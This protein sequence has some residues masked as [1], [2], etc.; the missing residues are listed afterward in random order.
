[1]SW[2]DTIIR[3]HTAVTEAVSHGQRMK[4]DR[5]FVWQEDGANPLMAN[6]GHSEGAVTGTTDL[7]T[8]RELDP[9]A[10]ALGRSFD[11]AGIAWYL[12]SVQFEEDTRFW[13]WEWVWEV[14]VGG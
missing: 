8:K 9:W 11:Q 10:E 7:F 6:N 2:S 12:N 5:Y 4:S 1:M 14:L 3:A 13:H